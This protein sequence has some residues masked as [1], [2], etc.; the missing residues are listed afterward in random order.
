MGTD[1][2]HGARQGRWIRRA[3]A[4]VLVWLALALVP[5]GAGAAPVLD[6]NCP[7]PANSTVG[8]FGDE[9]EAQTFTVQQTGALTRATVEVNPFTLQPGDFVIQILA[10][11]NATPVDVVLASATIP[12]ASVP[13]GPALLD[14]NFSSPVPV[15][16]GTTYAVAIGRPGNFT[17]FAARTRTGNPCD[18]AIFHNTGP[19]WSP[20][21]T[22]ADIVYQTF[23]EPGIEAF[24][25]AG[26][27]VSQLPPGALGPSNVFT[28]VNKRGQLFARVPGPGKLVVD[29]AKKPKPSGATASRKRDRGFVK[30]TKAKAKKAG[31]VKLRF[32]LNKRGIR[33]VLATRKLNG[34]GGVTYTPTGGTPRTLLFKIRIRI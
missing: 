34:F 17:S 16:A 8:A 21:A 10:T 23:V 18:G 25:S 27:Q 13:S 7:P 24:I 19:G 1:A 26:G 5:S 32:E 3:G 33:R 4:A 15:V 12:H 14:A 28:L 29:D 22:D 11:D 2:R 30:R 6:A 31:L 20:E 9:R